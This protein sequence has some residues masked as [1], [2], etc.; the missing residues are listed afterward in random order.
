MEIS[1]EKA[2]LI[3]ELEEKIANNAYNKYNN[4]GRGGWYRYPINYKDATMGKNTNGTQELS[5][6]IRML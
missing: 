6:L 4:Y 3:S 2:Q 1:L 5:T